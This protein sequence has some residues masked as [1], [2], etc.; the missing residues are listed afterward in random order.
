MSE[1][2]KRK[3][4]PRGGGQ[5]GGPKRSKG[6]SGGKWNVPAYEARKAEQVKLGTAMAVGDQGI[7]VTYARG[8]NAKAMRELKEL[9]AE[10]GEKMYGIKPPGEDE[11]GAEAGAEGQGGEA[12]EDIEASIQ[13]ELEAMKQPPKKQREA[14]TFVRTDL[15]CVFFV[16]TMAPVDPVAVVR[17]VCLD[18]RACGSPGERKLKY[19]NRLTPVSDTDRATEGGVLKV[20]RAIMNGTFK[21]KEVN[22]ENN[23]EKE[24][25][26]EKEKNEEKGEEKGKPENNEEA[27]HRRTVS[28]S[29]NGSH[30]T[31][32]W[33]TV[34]AVNSTPSARRCATPAT[35][36]VWRSSTASPLSSA[37]STRSTLKSP[38]KSS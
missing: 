31:I 18:A 17:Q 10:Y 3:E 11:G 16:K 4:R 7:W 6:G 32:S 23:D 21:L 25:S 14:F 38:T 34:N 28:R 13:R 8:M 30:D 2:Q 37:Q 9:W 22:D 33:L 19:I 29:T 20:A 15:E 24:K 12:E 1:G 36:R 35:S 26:D 27:G 5:Q